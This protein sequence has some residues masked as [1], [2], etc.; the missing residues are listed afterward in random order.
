[1]PGILGDFM[2]KVIKQI[3]PSS[4]ECNVTVT[5]A[6]VAEVK[7]SP[8]WNVKNG[9]LRDTCQIVEE[10]VFMV[11]DIWNPIFAKKRI[12]ETSYA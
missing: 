9:V 6:D 7:F 10:Y 5:C 4:V 12:Y 3:R 1:M 8:A 2:I 11:R